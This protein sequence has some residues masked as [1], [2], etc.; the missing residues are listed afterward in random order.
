MGMRKPKWNY[1]EIKEI[2]KGIQKTTQSCVGEKVLFIDCIMYIFSINLLAL[3]LHVKLKQTEEL[4]HFAS[5][6]HRK[7]LL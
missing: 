3:P 5:R 6:W 7:N 2:R 1:L 4:C